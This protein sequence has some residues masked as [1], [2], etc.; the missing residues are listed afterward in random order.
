MNKVIKVAVTGA[1]GQ[2]GY[3]LLYRIAS[4]Q[5]FGADVNVEL[6]LIELEASLNP[7]NG[8]VM[9]LEDCAFPLLKRVVCTSDINE[10]MRD[11][12]WVLLV[13]SVPRKGGME[14]ADLL[15]INGKVFSAQGKA[16][17][18][19]ASSDVKVLVIGNPCNTNAMIAM[20]HAPDIPRD[21]FFA[22]TMLDQLRAKAQL[23]KKTNSNIEDVKNLVI[24]GNH[25]ATQYPDFYHAT[26]S[27][28]QASS[29]IDENWLQTDF[30]ETVQKRGAAVI[31]ARGLSS[32]A[33]AANAIIKTVNCL[34]TN[35]DPDDLFSVCS[36]SSG[37]NDIDDGLIFSFPSST[38][39]G[40][41][42]IQTN[43]THNE[44]ATQK[45]ITTLEEL[46]QERVI[47]QDLKLI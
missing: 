37:K 34:I 19:N 45:I 40:V 30:I 26:I 10:G 6:H 35:T 32:A 36:C 17:N 29:I 28:K 43:V 44:F 16:I 1:A 24:W 25:S 8:V 13:G 18:D 47:A 3:A 38:L 5:M 20:N 22:M 42:K 15:E 31:K 33:S 41:T 46:R 39:N 14:R 2:I 12:N 9:E 4:G 11:V 23:A 7:L 27:G 21:R